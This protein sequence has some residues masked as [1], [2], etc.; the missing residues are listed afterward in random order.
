MKTTREHQSGQTVLE[1]ALAGIVLGIVLY[2]G[3]GAM[4]YSQVYLNAVRRR[5]V[6][7]EDIIGLQMTLA[8]INSCTQKS[9]LINVKYSDLQN[10]GNYALSVNTA[11]GVSFAEGLTVDGYHIDYL[12]LTTLNYLG[13]TSPY[14]YFAVIQL[15]AHPAIVSGEVIL[16]RYFYVKLDFSS[17]APSAGSTPSDC[18][19]VTKHLFR[20]TQVCGYGNGCNKV[21]LANAAL[22]GS[23]PPAT[24]ILG[25]CPAGMGVMSCNPNCVDANG[26]ESCQS[27]PYGVVADPLNPGK[28]APSASPVNACI[29]NCSSS[30][31]GGSACTAFQ[32]LYTCVPLS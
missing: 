29:V 21:A 7:L 3:V 2:I 12:R 32:A 5:S 31:P 6:F 28:F 10:T 26:I 4:S 8:D 27:Q 16:S 25:I 22:Q 11:G 23:A 17:S 13:S 15:R 18:H 9:G 14:S 1:V 24:A 20:Y 19:G 30:N